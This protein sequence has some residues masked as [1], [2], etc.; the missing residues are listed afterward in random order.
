[1]KEFARRDGLAVQR[2]YREAI[3]RAG[4]LRVDRKTAPVAGSLLIGQSQAPS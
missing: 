1:L 3:A 2:Y 4:D